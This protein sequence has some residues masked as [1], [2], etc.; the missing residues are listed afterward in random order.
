[1]DPGTDQGLPGAPSNALGCLSEAKDSTPSSWT[2]HLLDDKGHAQPGLGSPLHLGTG[3]GFVRPSSL[4]CVLEMFK[5]IFLIFGKYVI[6]KG[7]H[8]VTFSRV[9][10]K[11][12]ARGGSGGQTGFQHFVLSVQFS[13][14]PPCGIVVQCK[15]CFFFRR[16]GISPTGS[17]LRSIFSDSCLSVL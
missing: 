1:M 8:S 3:R 7:A 4:K 10:E 6:F 13:P 9:L 11:G 17:N 14:G 5:R 16:P 12:A 15:S 2:C